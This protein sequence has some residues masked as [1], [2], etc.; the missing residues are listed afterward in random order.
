MSNK[1][2]IVYLFNL[3]FNKRK[4]TKTN[5]ISGL[6]H[7]QFSESGE[8][9]LEKNMVIRKFTSI[10]TGKLIKISYMTLWTLKTL[11]RIIFRQNKGFEKMT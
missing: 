4:R 2:Y 6:L 7:H 5:V 8:T 1:F 11:S 10:K 9:D 3:T